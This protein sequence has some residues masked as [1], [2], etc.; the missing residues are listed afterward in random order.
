MK[1]AVFC[2]QANKKGGH[3]AA[4]LFQAKSFNRVRRQTP[5]AVAA[6]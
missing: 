1:L 6:G 2:R 5:S 3:Q 4:F